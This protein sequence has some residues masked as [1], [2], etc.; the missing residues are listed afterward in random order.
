MSNIYPIE[1][2]KKLSKQLLISGVAVVI[3]E[4]LATIYSFLGLFEIVPIT[5]PIFA[6]LLIILL[7]VNSMMFSIVWKKMERIGVRTAIALIIWFGMVVGYWIFAPIYYLI[8]MYFDAAQ[9]KWVVFAFIWEVPAVGGMFILLVLFLFRPIYRFL[10]GEKSK[11]SVAYIYKRLNL[12]PILVGLLLVVIVTFGYIIGTMQQKYFANMPPLEQWKNV[13]SGGTTALLVGV[14]LS[15]FIDSYFNR[16]RFYLNKNYDASTK[17]LK[18]FSTKIII[19]TMVIIIAGMS[20]STMISFKSAQNIALKMAV[21]QTNDDLD[22]FTSSEWLLMSRKDK[23][24]ELHHIKKGQNGIVFIAS[25]ENLSRLPVLDQTRDYIRNNH[26]GVVDD[27]QFNVKRII[28]KVNPISGEKIVS[29]IYVMDSYDKISAEAILAFFGWLFILVT[30]GMLIIFFKSAIAKPIILIQKKISQE[31]SDDSQSPDIATGD[32][33]EELSDAIIHYKSQLQKANANLESKVEEQTGELSRQILEIEEKNSF[34]ED[35][36]RAVMNILEDA[37]ITEVDL[38]KN[39]EELAKF[40]LA[41]ENA[42]DHII[43]TDQIGKIIYA[44]KAVAKT[45]GYTREEVVGKTPALWSG[46]MPKEFY[47]KMWETIKNKKETFAGEVKNRRKSGEE[48]TAEVSISPILDEKKGVKFYIGIERDVTKE[49]ELTEELR[50]EKENVEKKV[51]ERTR[52]L[53][54]EKAKL[55]ASINS[56]PIG[57][58]MTDVE[59]NVILMNGIAKSILCPNSGLTIGITQKNHE[60]KECDLDE[61]ELR[62]KESFD[63]KSAIDKVI[64]NGKPFEVKEILLDDVFLHVFITPIVI[65]KEKNLSVIGCVVLVENVTEEKVIERSKDEFFSIA[66]H[67]LRTPLTSIRGNISLIQEYYSEQVKD[68]E[69]KEMLEDIHISTVRLIDVVND[70][71]NVSR[72]EQKRMVFAKV[73]FDVSLALEAAI[74]ETEG[75]ATEKKLFVKLKKPAAKIEVIGD[76]DK[77]KEVVINLIGNALKFTKKGG[78]T[79][80]FGTKDGFVEVMVTDTGRGIAKSQQGLLFHKFTQAEN[81]PLT[82]DTTQGTGLGLYI[83]RMMIEGMGGEMV[84]KSSEVSHGSTFSFTLPLATKGESKKNMGTR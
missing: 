33:F 65:V 45:T 58:V 81:N 69:F 44:N 10:A 47:K 4:I 71:L 62:L 72:L 61:I 23:D 42:Y 43:I 5:V 39:N 59:Q 2:D 21:E 50:Q 49:R 56:L 17:H 31:S 75:V 74:K 48:Y 34:L 3:V 67:E 22:K 40:Q 26:S 53:T 27:Y 77:V 37:Q 16:L 8:S 13:I 30:T 28:F 78:V 54:E 55:Q 14:F 70:F 29:V 57:F 35:T 25:E 7:S 82:R 41:A 66:S 36:K 46:K 68:K 60:H 79:I 12:F 11:E 63:I 51:E 52:E 24:E 73:A 83:S 15:L 18:R 80:E 20:M 6:L 64:T 32:E 9:F 76:V 84:L 1:Q 38:K 19:S